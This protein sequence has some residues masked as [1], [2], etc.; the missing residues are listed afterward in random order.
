M[1]LGGLLQLPRAKVSLKF[2]DVTPEQREQFLRVFDVA[3][4]RGGG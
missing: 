4:Q 3:F 1:R 2:R